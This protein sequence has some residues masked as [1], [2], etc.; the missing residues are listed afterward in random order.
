MA[1]S[2]AGYSVP[3]ICSR[4]ICPSAATWPH[5]HALNLIAKGD[6]ADISLP[7]VL[8]SLPLQ[9]LRAN[10]VAA[11][12][13]RDGVPRSPSSRASCTVLPSETTY[14]WTMQ[15]QA[16]PRCVC[17]VQPVT[18]HAGTML[19]LVG[20]VAT[21]GRR[22]RR[23]PAGNTARARHFSG[24]RCDLACFNVFQG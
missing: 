4:D 18:H 22:C 20:P 24:G 9:R 13:C 12:L 5:N 17:S 19:A 2:P 15:I 6:A 14:E 11:F 8:F 21:R 1:P 16:T 10:S 3:G 7:C 23:G